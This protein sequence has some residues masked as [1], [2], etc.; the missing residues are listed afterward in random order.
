[1]RLHF[2]TDGFD[3]WTPTEAELRHRSFVSACVI[4]DVTADKVIEESLSSGPVPYDPALPLTV[5]GNSSSHHRSSHT[6]T[7][8]IEKVT[9]AS[10]P[11]RGIPWQRLE[12]ASISSSL[13]TLGRLADALRG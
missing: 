7:D 4:H 2:S 10:H 6:V 11:A 3:G 5:G 9:R 12:N 1:M 13:A 8:G